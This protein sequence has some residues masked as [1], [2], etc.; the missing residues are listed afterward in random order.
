[1]III[2]CINI[3]IIMQMMIIII[4]SHSGSRLKERR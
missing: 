2:I 4:R 3:S 1:M